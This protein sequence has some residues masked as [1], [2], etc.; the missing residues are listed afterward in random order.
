MDN[1]HIPVLLTEVCEYLISDKNGIYVDGTLGGGGHSEAILNQLTVSGK[2]IGI[3]LD[4]DAIEQATRRLSNFGEQFNAIQ[5]NFR[6]IKALLKNLKLKSINGLLLDLGVSSHQLDKVNRGFS[7][8]VSTELDMRLSQDQDIRAVDILNQFSEQELAKIIYEYGEERFARKIAQKI[9]QERQVH[10]VD[11]SEKLRSIVSSIIP[12]QYQIKS[13]ARVFQA[14]RIAVNRE[15]DNLVQCLN[16]VLPCLEPGGRLVI[17]SYHSLEDRIVKQFF[18]DNEKKCHCPPGFP[19]CVCGGKG[20][21][22][23]VTRKPILPGL[24]EIEKNSRARSG[25]LRVA[26]RI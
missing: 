6:E 5:T 9:V 24:D 13:L 25:K 10:P 14:L 2:V 22:E 17:I 11:S 20:M 16:D 4:R 7:Y 8:Q 18:K 23:I 1:F 15:L 19:I 3:D 12:F 21:L 26:Q